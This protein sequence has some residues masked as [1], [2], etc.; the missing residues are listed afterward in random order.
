MAESDWLTARPIAHRGLH[1]A[2]QG[3]IENTPS[4][5]AAAVAGNYGIEVDLQITADGEAMVHHDDALGRLTDGSGKL[6][7]KGKLGDGVSIEDGQKAARACAINVL[8]QVKAAL[9]DLDKVKQVARVGGF[10]NS[11]PSFLEGPKVMNGASD[12]MVAVLGDKGRHART[13]VGVAVLPADAAVEVEG[14][15]EIA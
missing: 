11:S 7:A 6:V 12:L 9:G 13:T 5:V 1:D 8:A 10:I 2:A 15:F 14:I 3:I 4:A